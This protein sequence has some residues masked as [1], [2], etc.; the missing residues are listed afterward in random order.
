MRGAAPPTAGR[1][2][3][4]DAPAPQAADQGP[5]DERRAEAEHDQPSGVGGLSTPRRWLRSVPNSRIW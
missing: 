2:E 5:D 1:A 4:P 3:R